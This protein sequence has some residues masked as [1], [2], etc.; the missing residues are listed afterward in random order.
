MGNIGNSG[1]QLTSKKEGFK[2]LI[3]SR[4]VSPPRQRGQGVTQRGP[5][6]R[7][8]GDADQQYAIAEDVKATRLVESADNLSLITDS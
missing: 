4:F 3:I 8:T 6:V 2:R 1:G 5:L 7:L